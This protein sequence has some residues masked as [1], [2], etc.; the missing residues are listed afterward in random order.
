[1]KENKNQMLCYSLARSFSLDIRLY[2]ER[3][4]LHY[5]SIYPLQK[6]PAEIYLD[7]LLTQ[8]H[9][10]GIV[11]TPLYQFY[12]FV[13]LTNNQRLILGPTSILHENIDEL[14]AT[15]RLLDVS[16]ENQ[17][18]YEQHLRSAP[19]IDQDRLAWLLVT[20][21]TALVAPISIE[22]VW[23]QSQPVSLLN[24]VKKEYLEEQVVMEEGLDI[25]HFIHQSYA[26]EQLVGAYIQE[27]RPDVIR[28]LFTAPPTIEAGKMSYN[29]LRQS[30][31]AGICAATL[32]SRQAISGGMTSTEAF[33]LSD[34]Y[35]QKIERLTD[36]LSVEKLIQE[37][38]VDFADHVKNM[39]NRSKG[40]QEI[41]QLCANYVSHHLFSPIKVE[42]MASSLGYSRSYLCHQFKQQA[43]VPLSQYIL[44]E[45][46]LASQKMLQ[47]TDKDLSEIAA[48]LGFS[49]QSHFQTVFKKI[50]NETPLAY[51][52]QRTY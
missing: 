11:T 40:K 12:G 3:I 49:S 19:L 50:V 34:L 16:R 35:I 27:G 39:Q 1:M 31:N 46:V 8:E 21:H 43:E 44:R 26:W 18:T 41:Y 33:H 24:Q 51:R 45:K 9:H 28:N 52:K 14:E 15:F 2:D 17:M 48:L 4:L 23:V 20:L 47:F 32:A 42:E 22:E 6:D 7:Q 30:K 36:F 25:R 13:T 29:A 37:M 10:I 38:L 5:E